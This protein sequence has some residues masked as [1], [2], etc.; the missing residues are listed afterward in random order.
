MVHRNTGGRETWRRLLEWDRGQ[1]VAERLAA[2]VLRLEGYMEIDPSHPLGGSDGLKDV[3]CRRDSQKWIGAAYFPR[4]QQT[5]GAIRTKLAD[6]AKGVSANG[7]SGI[8]F[9]TNQELTLGERETLVEQQHGI[10]V[11]I[12]H[13]ERVASILDSPPCYGIRLE[14]L[15]IEMSKEEQLAYMA[16]RDAAIVE[17]R[18]AIDA[19]AARIASKPTDASYSASIPV[20]TPTDISPSST[21]SAMLYGTRYTTC[22]GCDGV[23]A[24]NSSSALSSSFSATMAVTCPYCGRTQR[25]NGLW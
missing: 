15:D 13:L 1:A 20:V 11:D 25:W 2:H 19:M 7:A 6:D 10:A 22:K 23:Y 12:Y 9:V 18:E 4:G 8:A 16:S 14:F 3:L 21:S 24:V 5:L 17:L